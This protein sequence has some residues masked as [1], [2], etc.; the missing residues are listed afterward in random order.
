MFICIPYTRHIWSTAQIIDTKNAEVWAVNGLQ[1]TQ[2]ST[3]QCYPFVSQAK[4]GTGIG[5]V[6]KI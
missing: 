4:W 6:G 2:P 5:V 3:T 1:R